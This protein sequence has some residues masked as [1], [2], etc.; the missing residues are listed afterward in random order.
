MNHIHGLIKNNRQHIVFFI[1]ETQ[2]R[3]GG[4]GT[5]EEGQKI[6]EFHLDLQQ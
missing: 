4:M 3:L 2:E 1:Q 6:K 5:E